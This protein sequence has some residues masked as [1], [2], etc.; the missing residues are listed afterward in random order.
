MKKL[1]LLYN[2]I[3]IIFG[4]IIIGSGIGMLVLGGF[5]IEYENS[6]AKL[7]MDAL[8]ALGYFVPFLA[9]VKIVSGVAF[10]TK[11]FVPLGLVIFMPVSVNMVVF[12]IFL[13]PTTGVGAYFIL[14]M[15]TYLM[16]KHIED[17]R[18]L[19]KAKV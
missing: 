14:L 12:H 16:F 3:R 6:T 19:L 9:L 7:Y 8:E 13:E 15:N 5:P 10:V 2:T 4:L 1:N 11:R 17:Y 18:P